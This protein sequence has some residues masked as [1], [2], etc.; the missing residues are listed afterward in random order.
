MAARISSIDGL[1]GIAAL[2]VVLYHARASWWIGIAETYKA[3]GLSLNISSWIGYL[4]YPLSFGG[5]GVCLFFVL[6]GYCIHRRG[7]II[8]SKSN[9]NTIDFKTFF[10]RRFWRIYPTYVAALILTALIDYW[11]YCYSGIH[12]ANQDNS[13]YSFVISLLT[14]QGYAARFYGSNGVFWTLAMEI[15]LYLAYPLLFYISRRKGPLSAL[16]TTLA[17]GIIY[18]AAN[19]FINID[20]MFKYREISGP[21]FIPFWF[22]WAVGFYIAEIQ[23]GRAKDFKRNIWFAIASIMVVLALLLTV[24]KISEYITNF[25]WSVFFASVVRI[26]IYKGADS[27]WDCY[28]GRFFVFIGMFS[29]TLYAIHGPIL[30]AIHVAIDPISQSKYASIYP[31]LFAAI[32]TLFISFVS[33]YIVEYWTASRQIIASHKN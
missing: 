26:C 5:L 1:R 22:N 10:I 8:L 7:A 30:Y 9:N 20:G 28:L 24:F 14:L 19:S 29:Y 11:V 2:A 31:S 3:N 17:L 15:H 32:A 16:L 27:I 18:V 6:S 25:F 13:L 4:S 12:S 21:I 23:A 33:Y